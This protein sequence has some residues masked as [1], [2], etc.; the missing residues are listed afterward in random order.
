MIDV[1]FKTAVM[2]PSKGETGEIL[3]KQFDWRNGLK[4]DGENEIVF[5]DIKENVW[6][7]RPLNSDVFVKQEEDG[8]W[9]G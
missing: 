8:L 5:A 2:A 7:N 1:K 9:T 4:Y 3:K 6:W